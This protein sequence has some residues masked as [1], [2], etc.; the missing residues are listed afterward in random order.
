[1]STLIIREDRGQQKGDSAGSV[2]HQ[3][4]YWGIA[5]GGAHGRGMLW[6]CAAAAYT[7]CPKSGSTMVSLYRMYLLSWLP[8]A[9][10]HWGT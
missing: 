1:M 4:Q 2:A 3:W 8:S 5:S 7:P 10:Y 6:A 9:A